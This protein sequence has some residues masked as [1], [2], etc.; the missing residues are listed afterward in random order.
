MSAPIEFTQWRRLREEGLAVPYGWLSLSSYQWLPDVPGKLDLL[1]GYWSASGTSAHATFDAED[2][3]TT[4]DGDPVSG[5]LVQSLHEDESMHFVRHGDTLV[6]LGVRGGRYMIRT[7]ERTH[8]RLK[9]FTGVPIFPYDPDFIVP[10]Q[11]TA[12]HAPK[13]VPIDSF[14]PDTKLKTEL[15]GEVNFVLGGQRE[16]L[17][18]SQNVDG[19]LTLD[20]RDLTNGEQTAAWRF[21]TVKAPAADGSVTIDFNRTLNYPMAFSPHA[22]CPA[23]VE[24]NR[25]NQRVKAG[26]LLPR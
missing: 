22:V 3:V 11:Y 15:V 5:T 25:L 23:P 8:P 26:E 2:C 13:V 18:A 12:F 20:F 1:P 9:A 6:E 10:G 19:S 21:V 16:V 7:R 24:A 17:A 14:R 4:A